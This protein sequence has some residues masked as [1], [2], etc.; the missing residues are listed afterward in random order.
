MTEKRE[1]N[2]NYKLLITNNFNRLR[3]LELQSRSFSITTLAKNLYPQCST[4]A[5]SYRRRQSIQ[6]ANHHVHCHMWSSHGVGFILQIIAIWIHSDAISARIFQFSL[7][8]QRSPATRTSHIDI[9]I[10]LIYRVRNIQLRC[11]RI[12]HHMSSCCDDIFNGDV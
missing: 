12:S 7:L 2:W 1:K 3:S 10:I 9:L 8:Q 4:T 6:F 5:C 11:C